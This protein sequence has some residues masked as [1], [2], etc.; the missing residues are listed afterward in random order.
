MIF[1][2]IFEYAWRVRPDDL[3]FS[4]AAKQQTPI[5][6]P[7]GIAKAVVSFSNYPLENSCCN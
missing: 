3:L 7:A 1:K 5:G 4:Y 2:N 6:G